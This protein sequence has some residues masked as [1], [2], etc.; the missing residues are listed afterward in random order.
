MLEELELIT[1]LE[2][3]ADQSSVDLHR[4]ISFRCESGVPVFVKANEKS[5]QMIL[6]NL[7]QNAVKYSDSGS[8]ILVKTGIQ[9]AQPYIEICDEGM[10]ISQEHLEKIF[11]PFFREKE[12]IDRSISGVGLGLAIVKKLAQEAEILISVSSEKGKGSVFR[13]DFPIS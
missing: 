11:D 4:K 3:I 13:L 6:N 10:G 12:V 2:E 8:E 5:L 1:F 7:I 9:H